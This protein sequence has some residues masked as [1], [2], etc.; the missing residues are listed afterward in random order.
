MPKLVDVRT[1]RAKRINGHV[2]AYGKMPRAGPVKA[3]A[4]GLEGDEV[5][6]TRVHGGPDK[7]IY[8]YGAANYPL[9]IA[10]HPR[11]GHALIPGGFGENLLIDGL[12]ESDVCVGDHWRIGTT[13]VQP[14]QPRQPCATMARWFADPKMVKAMVANG[15]SGWYL[16]VLED[17]VIET[18]DELRLEHRAAGAWTIAEVLAASYAAPADTGLLQRL[19]EAPG[20]AI[21]WASWAARAAKAPAPKPKPL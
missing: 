16:R 3:R 9:W 1:G 11:H 20:L 14:C 21:A 8:A 5:A 13:L 17:G 15:R 12:L 7:A 4:M 19:A 10:D 2:T 6:N 18:G